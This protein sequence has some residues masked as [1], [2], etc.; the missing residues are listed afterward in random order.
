MT[1]KTEIY[2]CDICGNIVEVI[3]EGAGELVCCGENMKLVDFKNHDLG[4]EKHVPIIER[5]DEGA[6]IQ[7]G[8]ILHP[9]TNEHYIQFIEAVSQDGKYL[10]R[11]YLYPNDEPILNLKCKCEDKIIARE[12]CNIHGGWINEE[13]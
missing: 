7:V 3:I 2:K 1:N 4:E 12:Y 8:A 13:K 9:M 6:K 10:K 11:K 5:T